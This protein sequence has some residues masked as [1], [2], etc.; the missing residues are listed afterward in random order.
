MTI[1][2]KKLKTL[3][4]R[5]AELSRGDAGV[6]EE[7]RVRAVLDELEKT[8]PPRV[9][10][11]ILKFYYAAIARELRFSE[12]RIEFAGTLSEKT[13]NA[14]AAHF[15]EIYARAIAPVPAQNPEIL[16]GLR[17]QVGDDVY[18]ASLAGTLASLRRALSPA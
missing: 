12:A 8:F 5:L 2:N 18:D 1:K 11:T 17:V 7:S 16:G 9:L 15:S 6:A 3:A 4:L 13:A 14:L 10:R